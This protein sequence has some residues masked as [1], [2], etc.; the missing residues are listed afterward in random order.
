MNGSQHPP[1]AP[2]VPMQGGRDWDALQ[3]RAVRR[4]EA[5]TAVEQRQAGEAPV[6]RIPSLK[7]SQSHDVSPVAGR[8]RTHGTWI[9]ATLEAVLRRSGP[10][11]RR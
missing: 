8:V 11:R 10:T 2:Q 4:L 7:T 3:G 9:R 5:R 6:Q 1:R